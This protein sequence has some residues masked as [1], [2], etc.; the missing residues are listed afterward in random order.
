MTINYKLQNYI[1]LQ[2]GY[3]HQFDYKANDEKGRCFLVLGVYIE[4]VKNKRN[5]NRNGEHDVN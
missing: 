3:L 2:V 4:L 1:T 5:N